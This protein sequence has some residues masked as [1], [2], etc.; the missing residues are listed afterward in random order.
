[1]SIY[2]H[3]SI[4]IRLCWSSKDRTNPS[5]IKQNQHKTSKTSSKRTILIKTRHK[6]IQAYLQS[7]MIIRRTPSTTFMLCKIGGHQAKKNG[8][9]FT[10]VKPDAPASKSCIPVRLCIIYVINQW[11][12][13]LP[14]TISPWRYRW[15]FMAK[16]MSLIMH[17]I[18]MYTGRWPSS[19]CLTFTKW[20]MA[21]YLKNIDGK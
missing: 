14:P 3:F 8:L 12:A 4:S 18:Q 17:Q 2:I 15:I 13:G 20:F 7:Q 1:M 21:N 5:S 16:Y 10:K 9:N 11:M 19:R 6:S